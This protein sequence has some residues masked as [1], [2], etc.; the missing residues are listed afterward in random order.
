M[1]VWVEFGTLL[2][3][4][5]WESGSQRSSPCFQRFWYVFDTTQLGP[6]NLKYFFFRK[7]GIN[8]G[9]KFYRDAIWTASFGT[10]V[11]KTARDRMKTSETDENNFFVGFSRLRKSS[12]LN[13]LANSTGFIVPWYGNS[14]HRFSAKLPCQIILKSS[15]PKIKL[16]FPVYCRI[17]PYIY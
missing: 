3:P 10:R 13:L 4:S 7:N 17:S 9:S 8:C 12:K 2:S 14:V 6:W 16:N 15:K 1:R 11:G 5:R